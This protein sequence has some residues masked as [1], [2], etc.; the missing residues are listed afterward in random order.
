[1]AKASFALC[2]LCIYVYTERDLQLPESISFEEGA[3]I[4][5]GLA[6]AV[7]GLYAIRLDAG[8]KRLTPPWE[9]GGKGLYKNQP[10]VITG[11]ST[12]V[13]QFGE[14]LIYFPTLIADQV[15][16][17]VQLASLSGFSPIIVTAS[18]RHEAFLK[19]LGATHIVDRNAD[20]TSEVK[21]IVRSTPIEVV[22]NI[23]TMRSKEGL[24]ETWEL[25]APGGT[26]IIAMPP[27]PPAYLKEKHTDRYIANVFGDYRFSG[28][29]ALGQSL[30]A[31]LTDLLE[32]GSI[33]VRTSF[34]S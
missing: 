6:T 11:G 25:V 23:A 16:L 14:H 27:P 30:Y 21:K 10:I 7:V 22:Y 18:L 4:S 2:R 20:L 12:S 32:D 29:D 31:K 28:N 9:E 26:L 3:S 8:S 13:G 17:A 34:A 5:L 33:K 15:G 19:S 24:E 1:M